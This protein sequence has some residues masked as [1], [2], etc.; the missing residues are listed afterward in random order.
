MLDR[1]RKIKRSCATRRVV[2]V[3]L[4]AASLAYFSCGTKAQPAK[5]SA[6][7]HSQPLNGGRIDPMLFG[8]FVELLD[9]V[10]PG[11]WAE[12]LN[13]R[14][15]EGVEAA[16]NWSYYDGSPDICDRRWDTNETW[17]LDIQNAFNGV[18]CARLNAA[19]RPASLMQSGLS[20]RRGIRYTFSGYLRA[21]P[22]VR[23]AVRLKFLLPS[24]KWLTLA[25][26][27][28]PSL[29][30]EWKKYSVKL[31][32]DGQTDQAVFEL[33]GA[34]RGNLWAD[35]LSLMPDDNLNGWRRDVVEAIREVRPTIIRWGGSSVDPGQY[36]WKNG[37]GDRDLRVP[38][39]NR[40]WGR[41]DPNDVGIDEFCQFCELVGAE[42][43]VCVSFADGVQSAADLVEYCNG[44]EA[45][46]WGAK[47][48]ANGHPA[49]YHVKYWQVGNEI[50]GNDPGYLSRIGEFIAA[51]KKTDSK[52]LFMTSFPTQEL[53][54][55]VGKD[56]AY[57]CPHH[58]TTDFAGCERDFDRIAGMI[59]HTAGCADVKIAVTEWNIDAGSWGLGRARQATLESALLNARY[60]NLM[61]RHSDKVKIACRSNLANSYC[62][63]IIETGASGSGVLR[64]ASYHVME[65]YSRHA[66]P[67]PLTIEK[68]DDRLDLFA[69][70]SE[71]RKRAVLFAV[72]LKSKPVELNVGCSGYE[73]S[74][75]VLKAE[76]LCDTLN[77]GQPDV[78][79]HWQTPERVK[80]L[81][82][83][84]TTNLVTL[85]GL[86]ATAIE[87]ERLPHD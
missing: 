82:L 52:A 15:F 68:T 25:S 4:S 73:S 61:M 33:V 11:M 60:L 5:V 76:S 72:N 71:D 3:V 42:P 69:C 44:P 70:G 55:R 10:V 56:I 36:K 23:A 47:R 74:L 35:K 38:W 80:I 28:L 18:R 79:N 1:D 50:S 53:L 87:C 37:T 31:D 66:Q 39:R 16:A 46:G 86:S 45:T 8:N 43:L 26:A 34:G 54:D 64:R 32:S 62:G 24:G 41:I 77:A 17:T 48:A 20:T 29:S 21:D 30:G 19:S 85:P 81:P 2:T 9:D 12:L 49:P 65:L 58:Y 75:R 27:N 63:A 13:D 57:V 59:D 40:N 51:M 22:G 78:I 14:S 7:I 83:A 84:T 6:V 67:I